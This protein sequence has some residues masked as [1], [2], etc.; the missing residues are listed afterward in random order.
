MVAR[1]GDGVRAR[2]VTEQILLEAARIYDARDEG[3]AKDLKSYAAFLSRQDAFTKHLPKDLLERA[4]NMRPPR[5]RITC[6]LIGNHSAGKSSFTNWYIGEKIQKESVAIETAGITM[7]RRGKQ[8]TT[9]RGPQTMSAFPHI[10]GL[11]KIEGVTDFLT[12]EFSTSEEKN[13]PLV[14]FIDTPGLTDGTL[15]YPFDV[16]SVIYELAEHATMIMVFLDPIGKA[17]V[18]RCMNVV[19]KLAVNHSAKMSYYLTKFDTA[20]DEID[21]T[22]VVSQIVQELQGR[23]RAT[24]A[25]KLHTMFLPDRAD[26]QTNQKVPNKI[27]E[28]CQNIRMEI[29][30][31]VQDVLDELSKDCEALSKIVDEKIERNKKCASHNA[32]ATVWKGV[33][34]SAFIVFLS[35]FVIW[36][37]LNYADTDVIGICEQQEVKDRPVNKNVY[38]TILRFA[39]GVPAAVLLIVGV[40]CTAL[41]W[42]KKTKVVEQLSSDEMRRLKEIQDDIH[43]NIE[44]RHKELKKRLTDDAL[45]DHLA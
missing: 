8:R 17:L 37:L 38:C 18:S 20:G 6:L 41:L 31:R 29:D 7:I 44:K 34:S 16:E 28:L 21:R 3:M 11:K 14:E 40:V 5:D 19:E 42:L 43:N 45:E 33:L 22:N 25:L 23:V 12:T 2:P 24:H 39:G 1:K 27:G 13:F 30:S 36:A 35:I 10:Q 9:W 26:E 15:K 32:F 4:V